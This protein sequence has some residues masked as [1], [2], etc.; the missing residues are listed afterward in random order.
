MLNLLPNTDHAAITITVNTSQC[1]RGPGFWKMNTSN[2]NTD[3]FDRTFK[4]FWNTWEKK[5]DDYENKKDW[6]E[7]T[8]VKIKEISIEVSRHLSKENKIK[9]SKLEKNLLNEKNKNPPDKDC[10]DKLTNELNDLY[11]HKTEGAR[12]RARVSQ[13]EE[14]EKSSKFFFSQE[15]IHAR[16]KLWNQIKDANGNIK[17]GINNILQEQVNFYSHLM[18][19]EGWDKDAA[20]ALLHNLD[21]SITNEQKSACEK[22]ISEEE[23]DKAIKNLKTGRSPGF[24]GIPSEFY[25]KYWHLI[26]SCF[27]KVLK[28]IEET[29]ELCISQYRGVICLLFKQGDRDEIS[30]WRP[31][32]LLNTDY[33]IIAIIYASRLRGILPFIINEDQKAYIEGRQITESVRLTQDIID[34]TD[35]NDRP[36]AIIFLDQKKAYDRVE[37]EYLKLCLEKFGFGP[38]FCSWI[39]MLYKGGQSCIQ[40]NGFISSFFKITRSMRQGCP[41][42][43]FLYVIQAEPMAQTIRKNT[44]IKGIDLPATTET[45]QITAK[46]SMF[47]DD[48]QIFISTEASII[49]SFKTLDV[50][51]KASGAKLNMHK[52]KGLYIGLWKG[53]SP[54]FKK[55][56]WVTSVSGLGTEFG[57]N[58]NYEDIWMR[59]FFKFKKKIAQWENRDLT[60]EGKKILINSYIM[61]SISYLADIYTENIPTNFIKDTKNLIR[62][63]LWK[64]KSWRVSQKN[65]GLS[66]KHGGLE[67]KDLDN[68]VKCKKLKWIV[69]IHFNEI[70]KW[71]AYG[72]Y[73]IA[74][75]D[76]RFGIKDFL[77]Q[78]GNINGLNIKLP[79]FYKTCIPVWNECI[80][81]QIVLTRSDVMEQNIFGNLS[82]SEKKHSIFYPNWTKSKLVKIKDIWNPISNNWYEGNYIFHKLNVRRNWIAEYKKI[83]DCIPK[84]WKQLIKNENV[85]MT[86]NDLLH[87]TLKINHSFISVNEK[88][89]SYKKV[90]EKGLYKACLYP[91]PMPTCV[92]SWSRTFQEDIS[93][94]DIFKNST[95]FI[96][97]RKSK[98]LHWRTLHKAIYSE[99]R[100]R[101]MNKSNG[102]C[103]VC[104]TE[105]ETLCH[106]FFHC[107]TIKRVWTKIGTTLTTITGKTYPM[108]IKNVILGHNRLTIED[109]NVRIIY[110]FITLITKWFIW[111][112]RNNVKY[113]TTTIQTCDHI[114]KQTIE[115]CKTEIDMIHSSKKWNKCNDELKNYLDK[116]NIL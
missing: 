21:T 84:S 45:G 98:D 30:N 107:S 83:K 14:G 20:N 52:T 39:I 13:Y 58:I 62:D 75:A 51:C 114:Y 12:I 29:E 56:R 94:V 108:S 17:L 27:F 102:Q 63:F 59:K 110:N 109:E 57:Y 26:K 93:I 92:E 9:I 36:G 116:I 115:C 4:T 33:K 3:L 99:E 69:R 86:K 2:I 67:L 53:K 91:A 104:T 105:H 77:L 8:K 18:T 64:G 37:W 40:T 11:K 113:G 41:I 106:L 100:L 34:Y 73:C 87:D 7:L 72:K 1:E 101:I 23:L 55:I 32:T 60:L 15:K 19:S 95:H 78:C 88:I 54:I 66:K 31:I 74:I 35:E 42:A 97:H 16:S 44:K 103:N 68:F 80:S 111:K 25:I 90:K 89:V 46:I 22:A 38:R 112:H 48:T 96:N 61:S 5:I 24:D 81:K 71:N 76:K 50:Y 79:G 49:E 10:I 65:L 47:A 28:E 6:W 70:G 85:A 82:I 43:S